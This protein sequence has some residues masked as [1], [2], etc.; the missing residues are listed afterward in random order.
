MKVITRDGFYFAQVL[1]H[2]IARLR[3]FWT[4][5]ISEAKQYPDFDQAQKEIDCAHVFFKG[6]QIIDFS[7]PER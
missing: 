2:Q 3:G 4:R 5:D 6:S 1:E 7:V